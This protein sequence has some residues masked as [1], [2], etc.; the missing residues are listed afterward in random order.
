MAEE[1]KQHEEIRPKPEDF[2]DVT[3]GGLFADYDLQTL[4]DL[5]EPIIGYE[6]VGLYLSFFSE[7]K[8]EEISPTNTHERLLNRIQMNI[9]IF[10]M[11]R[12]QL[13][14]MGLIKTYLE[15]TENYDIYHYVLYSPYSPDRF[16][17][18]TLYYGLLKRTLGDQ[19]AE[20]LKGLY[21]EDEER[22]NGLEVTASYREVYKPQLDAKEYRTATNK[23]KIRGRET[24]HANF[25]FSKEDFFVACQNEPPVNTI[26]EDSF[27]KDEI[28][29]I[30]RIAALY[31]ASEV[32]MARAVSITFKAGEPFGKRI[33]SRAIRRQL[34][35]DKEF[36]VS[37]QI[38]KY[39]LDPNISSSKSDLALKINDMELLPPVKYLEKL[40]NGI[41]VAQA[42]KNILNN[43][44]AT[45]ML[46]NPVLNAL[47]TYTLE[48]QHNTLKN[49][50]MEKIAA[51]LVRDGAKTAADA[52]NYLYGTRSKTARGSAKSVTGSGNGENDG[53]IESKKKKEINNTDEEWERLFKKLDD[54]GK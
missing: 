44:S 40:Q 39:N 32:D 53:K 5:Y 35:Y 7:L 47:V 33:D 21:T 38:S 9:D 17:N 24:A 20:M 54:G 2:L 4:V 19:E 46:S 18:N 52:L 14:G 42:D 13:E 28:K 51:A 11:A 45:Y 50:Y 49:N 23:D 30:Q 36:K 1:V 8:I 29:E 22:I 41:E 25:S 3:F 15:R 10:N 37:D 12:R 26:T 43:I 6:A 48:T 16:I 34:D 27:S 31:G